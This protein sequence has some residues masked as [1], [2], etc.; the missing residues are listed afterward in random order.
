MRSLRAKLSSVFLL[1]NV[2]NVL[3]KNVIK[4][5]TKKV[6]FLRENL[7]WIADW[8]LPLW[9]QP[10]LHYFFDQNMYFDVQQRPTTP[11]LPFY[12][13]F[14]D[15]CSGLVHLSSGRYHNVICILGMFEDYVCPVR[16]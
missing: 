8:V 14:D 3:L 16:I 15:I 10:G 12:N 6:Y 9:F 2:E 1:I 7:L 4:K 5:K 11:Q 13:Q